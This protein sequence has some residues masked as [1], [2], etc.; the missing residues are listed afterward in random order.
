VGRKGRAGATTSGG[1][2]GPDQQCHREKGH[3][4]GRCGVGRTRSTGAAAVRG[5]DGQRR[6]GAV[7]WRGSGVGR[8]A[9]GA[10]DLRLTATGKSR[11]MRGRQLSAARRGWMGDGCGHL[12]ERRCFAQQL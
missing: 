6:A 7:A 9:T 2:A 8:K 4:R 3:D 12:L 10:V 1:G 11:R 5:E